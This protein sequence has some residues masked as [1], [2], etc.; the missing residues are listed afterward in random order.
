MTIRFRAASTASLALVLGVSLAAAGCGKYSWSTLT[1]V[2]AFKDGNVLYQQK[3]YRKAAEKYKEV[4][5]NQAAAES[6]P[7]LSKAWFFLA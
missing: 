1:A 2:K 6:F 3:D 4:T 7:D 5:D